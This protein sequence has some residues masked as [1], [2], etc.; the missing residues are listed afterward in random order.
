MRHLDRKGKGMD[1]EYDIE[2]DTALGNY[3]E[4]AHIV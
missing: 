1:D 3:I 2:Q 4:Q